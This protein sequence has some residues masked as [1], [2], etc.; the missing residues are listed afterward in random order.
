MK[1]LWLDDLFLNYG[2][3]PER[4]ATE[5]ESVLDSVPD[6]VLSP[7]PRYFDR[8]K[9]RLY[10]DKLPLIVE[11]ILLD[12]GC[13]SRLSP[14]GQD[15]YV[16]NPAL[17]QLILA[18]AGVEAARVLD[19]DGRRTSVHVDRKSIERITLGPVADL[20]RRCWRLDLSELLFQVP[21]STPIEKVLSIRDRYDEERQN[22]SVALTRLVAALT[23][24]GEP[25]E[26]GVL[27]QAVRTASQE[28]EKAFRSKRM[29]RIRRGLYL[30]AGTGLAI[31]PVTAQHVP[32]AEKEMIAAVAVALSG[33]GIG[34][35]A[36]ETRIERDDGFAYL[37]RARALRGRET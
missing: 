15:T 19:K 13:L 14:W 27:A 37:H 22:L 16:G 36:A 35:A 31:V 1:L 11:D 10:V 21:P 12:R 30:L 34:V 9:S 20:V 28:Y 25:P 24:P 26:L 7:D 2:S 17:L 6:S 3:S 5:V 32:K 4:L 23:V 33:Y 8:P 29:G 18:A